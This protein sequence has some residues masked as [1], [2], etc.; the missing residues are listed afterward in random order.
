LAEA[1]KFISPLSTAWSGG[2]PP[3]DSVED[4]ASQHLALHFKAET[5]LVKKPT[6]TL[7]KIHILPY[8]RFFLKKLMYLKSGTFEYWD[9]L[10]I[11]NKCIINIYFTLIGYRIQI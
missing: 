1:T 5:Q 2:S 4:C 7:F 9:L 3:R 11:K 8:T 10:F 6:Y